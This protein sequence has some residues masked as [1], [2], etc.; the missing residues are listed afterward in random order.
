MPPAPTA[1]F[2]LDGTLVDSAPDLTATLNRI[3]VA[4]GL[5]PIALEQARHL[6][7]RGAKALLTRGFEVNG[8][9]LAERRLDELFE[10]FLV[11]YRV[12]LADTSQPY[13]GAVAAL[14]RLAAAGWQLAV[15]T[16]KLTELAERLL[17]ALDL[18]QR[19][20][21]VSGADAYAVRKPHPG[22]LIATIEAAGGD[23]EDAVMI[24]DSRTDV[25][26]AR[27][28]GVPVIAVNFGYSDVPV[29]VLAP[30]AIVSHFDAMHETILRLRPR[31]AN[32]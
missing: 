30:D 24:G 9:P 25:D 3:I 13:P 17:T 1:V 12:H 26:T 19:F 4:E 7:G 28:A 6:M 15:C 11:D 27:A 8:V 31:S 16:N 18:R 22:H 23:L 21:V 10:A 29:Q 2:D 5:E 14:D 20:S 32:A